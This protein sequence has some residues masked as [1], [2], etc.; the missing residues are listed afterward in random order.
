MGI[1]IAIV[2]VVIVGVAILYNTLVG[3]KNNVEKA[4]AS[5]DV[6]LKKRY[7][8]IPNLV[9][10]VK[11]YM[12][13]EQETLTRITALR[14]RA[15]STATPEDQRIELEDQLTQELS[16]L[17]IAFEAYPDLKAN[18]SFL[19]LQQS[20]NEIEEQISASRRFYNTAVTSY[21]NLIEM[22]PSNILANMMRCQRKQVFA[23]AANERQNV[24]VGALFN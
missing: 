9:S 18:Q 21:N 24:N 20:L 13:H 6:M 2:V 19:A 16:N 11:T 7:D 15:L 23:A 5:V 8:L 3:H 4:F 10:T 1:I 12:E 17:S 14:S 22:F